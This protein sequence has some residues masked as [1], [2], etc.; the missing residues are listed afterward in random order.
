M[1]Y[2]NGELRSKQESCF[3]SRL[4]SQSQKIKSGEYLPLVLLGILMI[5]LFLLM[6]NLLLQSN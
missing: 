2:L 5:G 4:E 6:E 3:W 1:K